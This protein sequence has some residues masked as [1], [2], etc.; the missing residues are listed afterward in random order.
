M[1]VG[2]LFLLNFDCIGAQDPPQA[3]PFVVDLEAAA[4]GTPVVLNRPENGV[5]ALNIIYTG[6]VDSQAQIVTTAF[7]SE[8]GSVTVDI[9]D[10]GDPASKQPQ[11]VKI[12]AAPNAGPPLCLF[13]PPLPTAAQYTGRLIITAEGV[14]PMITI[15]S[16]AR[17]EAVTGPSP[18]QDLMATS[19]GNPATLT[20]PENGII[21]PSI[22]YSGKIPIE[23]QVNTTAFTSENGSI[24]AEILSDCGNPASAQ[25]QPVKIRV[26]PNTIVPLCLF[27]KPLPIAAKYTGGSLPR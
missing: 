25:P 17:P 21:T 10:C 11:P 15:I 24:T 2:V 18:F 12:Q 22:F 14:A 27:L 1:G 8:S 5:V 3:A 13:I 20:R 23:A 7:T 26:E 4:S 6:T 9:V 19:Q 16:V